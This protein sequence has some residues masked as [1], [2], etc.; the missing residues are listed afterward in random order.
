[1][2]VISRVPELVAE[3]F[4]GEDKINLKEIERQTGLN[5]PV[6]HR[7]VRGRVDRADFDI[8]EIW[9]EYLE[10]P[11]GELLIYEPRKYSE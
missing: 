1:M 3:K 5:Y 8:L 2:P 10:V 6:I 4:G 11:V 7:W 9:C